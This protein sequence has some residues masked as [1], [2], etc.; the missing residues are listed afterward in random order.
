MHSNNCGSQLPPQSCAE[1][2]AT[3]PL[4]AVLRSTKRSLSPFLTA[5]RPRELPIT[6]GSVNL[7]PAHFLWLYL[8]PSLSRTWYQ[9]VPPSSSFFFNNSSPNLHISKYLSSFPSLPQQSLMTKS[10]L[11]PS[12][13]LKENSITLFFSIQYNAEPSLVLNYRWFRDQNP[14]GSVTQSVNG[15]A[16]LTLSASTIQ[17]TLQYKMLYQVL[18]GNTDMTSKDDH[19]KSHKEREKGIEWTLRSR[20]ASSPTRQTQPPQIFRS[21]HKT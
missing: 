20:P 12:R 15:M 4:S 14:G 9:S 2:L 10:L 17:C 18:I 8:S 19:N 21:S 7:F 5:P 16:A 13:L 6:N 11:N 3:T 1:S